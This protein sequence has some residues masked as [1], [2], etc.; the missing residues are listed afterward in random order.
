VINEEI[1]SIILF[2]ISLISNYVWSLAKN[3][4]EKICESE[5]LLRINF[6]NKFV[7]LSAA[8]NDGDESSL[9]REPNELFKL[10]YND[11]YKIK[12]YKFRNKISPYIHSVLFLTCI[13]SITIGFFI[14]DSIIFKIAIPLSALL[15]QIIIVCLLWY[16]MH[17]IN[18]MNSHLYTQKL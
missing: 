14:K 7:Y 2:G 9:R 4:Q 6:V 5:K 3:N 1:I 11:A 15:I 18:D 8:I 12:L 10:V 13:T 17:K 16:Y